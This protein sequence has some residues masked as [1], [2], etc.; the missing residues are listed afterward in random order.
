[1]VG[2]RGVERRT[3]SL[4]ETMSSH[5]QDQDASVQTQHPAWLHRHAAEHPPDRKTR[6]TAETQ[7]SRRVG[8]EKVMGGSRRD[9]REVEAAALTA[10]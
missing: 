5:V 9:D 7:I 8:G 6:R 4:H 2:G 1:M 3:A 10:Q